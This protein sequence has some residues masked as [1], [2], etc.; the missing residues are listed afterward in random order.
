ME[1]E[2]LSR[3][4]KQKF[5]IFIGSSFLHLKSHLMCQAESLVFFDSLFPFHDISHL[6]T[7][8]VGSP[9]KLFKNRTTSLPQPWSWTP[10]PPAWIRATAFCLEFL[11][12]NMAPK[13]CSAYIQITILKCKFCCI[14]SLHVLFHSSFRTKVTEFSYLTHLPYSILLHPANFPDISV[15]TF[16]PNPA[17]IIP[18]CAYQSGTHLRTF[19]VTAYSF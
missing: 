3:G 1:G 9:L 17:S 16:C 13:V 5:L 11:F 8:T 7:N 12:I 14:N 2:R 15:Y 4:E 6:S 19:V 10:L 18:F